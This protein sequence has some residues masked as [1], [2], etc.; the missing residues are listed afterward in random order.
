MPRLHVAGDQVTTGSGIFFCIVII[1]STKNLA[2]KKSNQIKTMRVGGRF[3]PS[4]LNALRVSRSF[5]DHHNDHNL[6]KNAGKGLVESTV[7]SPEVRFIPSNL[8]FLCKQTNF[9]TY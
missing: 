1:K 7:P 6:L 5:V 9:F 4:Q 2:I 3:K 8:P